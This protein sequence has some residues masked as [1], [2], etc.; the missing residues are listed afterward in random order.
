MNRAVFLVAVTLFHL[1]ST[2]YAAEAPAPP[3]RAEVEAGMGLK[4]HGDRIRGQRDTTGDVVTAEQAA[5]VVSTAVDLD[6]AL[7]GRYL[8]G[9]LLPEKL[10]VFEN[11][12]VEAED[13]RTYKLPW[14]GRFSIPFG[15]EVLRRVTEDSGL[16]ARGHLLRYATSLSEPLLPVSEETREAGLGL[17]AESNLHHWVGYATLGVTAEPAGTN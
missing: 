1:A 11:T 8:E 10:Q 15:L 4:S 16:T 2:G 3:T 9:P 6:V 7:A 17:T 14:C 5:D 13:P 12:L